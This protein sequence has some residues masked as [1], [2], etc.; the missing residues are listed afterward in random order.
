M[1]ENERREKIMKE[2]GERE[3]ERRKKNSESKVV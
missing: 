1:R 3:K 2:W